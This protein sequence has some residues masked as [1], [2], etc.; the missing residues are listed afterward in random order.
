MRNGGNK[1]K[2]KWNR[3]LQNLFFTILSQLKQTS[4]AKFL[5]NSPSAYFMRSP[6]CCTTASPHSPI[7]EVR[8]HS[9]TEA[10]KINI[11]LKFVVSNN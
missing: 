3:Q 4:Q 1:A 10:E 6:A 8:F 9:I 2:N 7:A 11:E 5:P